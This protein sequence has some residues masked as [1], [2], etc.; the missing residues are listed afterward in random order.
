MLISTLVCIGDI[1]KISFFQ[2]SYTSSSF[3]I[4]M[5]IKI[6]NLWFWIFFRKI[7][8]FWLKCPETKKSLYFYDILKT[9][10]Q[11]SIPK[12]TNFVVK[13]MKSLLPPPIIKF[14]SSKIAKI[15]FLPRFFAKNFQKHKKMFF[16]FIQQTF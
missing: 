16:S 2:N 4:Q 13:Q 9:Y 5:F 10:A 3:R 7:D 1:L 8:S 11:F 6:S 14:P 15:L 12:I